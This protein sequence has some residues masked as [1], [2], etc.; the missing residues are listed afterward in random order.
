M[1][2]VGALLSKALALSLVLYRAGEGHCPSAFTA[3]CN[4]VVAA[5]TAASPARHPGMIEKGQSQAAEVKGATPESRDLL[6]ARSLSISRLTSRTKSVLSPPLGPRIPDQCIPFSVTPRHT[7]FFPLG[8]E[9]TR[10]PPSPSFRD[11]NE[12][13]A[14]EK[15]RVTVGLG[16]LA[17]RAT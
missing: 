1:E 10:Y 16:H 3:S 11:I 12:S 15:G 13:Q 7:P 14:F 6:A 5:A 8:P 2:S 9:G 4:C 17:H